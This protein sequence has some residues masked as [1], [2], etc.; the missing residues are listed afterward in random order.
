MWI[1]DYYELEVKDHDCSKLIVLSHYPM[2]NWNGKMNGSWHFHG[3][4][5]SNSAFHWK[6]CLDVGV[7]A[8]MFTPQSLDQLSS[9]IIKNQLSSE[10]WK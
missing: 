3:H 1:K 4:Q 2:W 6:N 7:D 8:N 9:I 5:H 10:D